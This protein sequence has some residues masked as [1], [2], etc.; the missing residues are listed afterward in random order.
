MDLIM[1]LANNKLYFTTLLGFIIMG[2]LVGAIPA[3][4]SNPSTFLKGSTPY[5][6]TYE[7]W[8]TKWW[9]WNIQIPKD[10]HPQVV[11]PNL[12]KC[13]VG[14][15]GNVSFLTHI[16]QGKSEYN[17]TIPAGL[18]I[19]I[20]ILTGEC[21]SDEAKSSVPEEMMKCATEGNKYS[22][23][24]VT[25]DGVRLDGL[26][27]ND[28]RSKVFNMTVPENNYLDLN[29]GQWKAATGG[30]FAFLEPLSVGNHTVSVSARVTNPID[31]AYNLNYNTQ[32]L[33]N[34]Q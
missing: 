31:P 4:S 18:A 10:Q 22:T 16:L 14:E 33:L 1:L 15:S 8:M 23:F 25:V 6:V 13:P 7:D 17:C 12:I 28:A 3:Y 34:V 9:Q 20:P 21:T 32:Y 24:D 11:D 19:M 26:D 29:P 30:Y 5:G 2:A 27:Q